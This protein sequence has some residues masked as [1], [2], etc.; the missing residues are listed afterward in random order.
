MNN[1]LLFWLA[2]VLVL[3]LYINIGKVV[4]GNRYV[5]LLADAAVLALAAR[6][7]VA[8]LLNGRRMTVLELLTA[9][10]IVLGAIQIFNPNVPT[11]MAGI[12]GSRRLIFQMLG[13]FIGIAL[14]RNRDD[15]LFLYKVLA[16]ASVPILLYAAKQFLFISDFDRALI[17]TNTASIVSWSIYGK[18]RAFGIFNGP[19]HLG[20]FAGFMFWIG[21]GLF[22]ETRR[23]LALLL[24]AVAFAACLA[25]LTRGSIIAILA[26]FPVVMFFV[27][28]RYRIRVA[29]IVVV[30]AVLGAA[31]VALL[32]SNSEELD[33]AMESFASLENMLDDHRLMV[34]FEGYERALSVLSTHPLGTGMGSSGD[35]MESHFHPYGAIHVTSHNLLLRIAL[36]TGIPGLL[37]FLILAGWIAFVVIKLKKANYQ[38][39]TVVLLGMCLIVAITGITGST[40][41]AYPMNLIFWTLC[42]GA[43]GL[44]SSHSR[45]VRFR[46]RYRA[47]FPKRGLQF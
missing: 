20:L 7:V 24:S 23:K 32:R 26:S 33:R 25:S 27:F 34:R 19:F 9:G 22:I 11:L 17:D 36:E 43:V 46:P 18:V 15:L 42:G 12:E 1:R 6:V 28:K 35:A 14:V 37:L 5:M 16:V 4:T 31:S 21:V 10:F 8:H 45:P 13:V 3:A 44:L 40:L 30:V 38:G 39:A 2:V 29:A 47:L 41:G